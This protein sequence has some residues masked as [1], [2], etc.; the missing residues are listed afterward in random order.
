MTTHEY[1]TPAA[2]DAMQALAA[3]FAAGWS[4]IARERRRSAA[5]AELA[6]LDDAA[7]RDIGL[8]RP[9]TGAVPAQVR[10]DLEHRRVRR[11]ASLH[12]KP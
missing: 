12:A 5:I 10:G 2:P 6:R 3:S 11:A 8:A 4:W 1:P 7:R 9:A